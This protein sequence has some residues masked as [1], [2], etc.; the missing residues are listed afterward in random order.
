MKKEKGKGNGLGFLRWPWN[1]VIYVLLAVALR[2]FAIPV[3][4]I[5][6]GIQQKNN[7]HG[8]AEG[9]C[10]SRTR[11]KLTWL[12]WG[13]LCLAV[14]VCLG[15]VFSIGLGQDRAYWETMD[16]VTLAV[17]G[18]GAVLLVLLGVWLCYVAVRDAFFPEKSTLAQSIRRQLPYP[19]EAP[20][21]AE[22]FA[23]VDEDL[24]AHGQWFGPV[25][26]GREW[27]LGDGVNRIDRIRGIFVTNEIHQH[28][29]ETGVRTRRE[30][31][32]VLIDDRWQRT[33]TGF[34]SLNDL[35]AAADCL[36]LRVPEAR[37][38][39]NGQSTDFW[40]M[41]ESERESF[42]RE[43]R[44]RRNLRASEAA[45]Q[46]SL[47]D[48]PQDMIFLSGQ[49]RTSRVTLEL[50]EERLRQCLRDGTGQFSLT[51]TRP[52]PAGERLFRELRV[53]AGGGGLL[54]TAVFLPA[55][56]GMEQCVERR[57][58]GETALELVTGWL[59]REAPDVAGWTPGRVRAPDDRGGTREAPRRESR[60]KLYLVRT[61]GLTETH[62]SFTG[63]DVE[64]AAEGL[65]DGAY[66]TVELTHPEGYLWIRI[67]AG[68]KLDARCTVEATRADP[69][70]LRF[71]R[72]KMPPRQ[73]AAWLL[74]YP[75]GEYLPGGKEW[76]DFT[77]QVK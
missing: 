20:P 61:N 38:G 37:R 57:A 47:R 4:L 9:Y 70:K 6:M 52:V 77:K 50:V 22:L 59:R 55:S 8:A 16:Y 56:G 48:G 13:A 15:A 35:E 31:E 73:A 62:T 29:T 42:E 51:S 69:D 36:A 27:V 2:L 30:M 60:A 68:D 23:M 74:G 58:D 34:N 41:N 14:A 21:V 46:E 44:Q 75:H 28:R 67:T 12:I 1:A 33:G 5:L 66:Q 24:K 49:E 26:I 17:S 63:E 76:K 3:I 45:R 65:V 64:V 10:L 43:F 7:P 32:L 54:V 72:T 19:E 40:T 39:V 25:G 11:R 71:F 53:A 18:G